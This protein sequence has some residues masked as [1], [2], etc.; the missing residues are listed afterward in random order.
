MR[1]K[2]IEKSQNEISNLLNCY[3]PK[4][5]IINELMI[6]S[7]LAP[8]YSSKQIA[9][10]TDKSNKTIEFHKESLKLKTGYSGSAPRTLRVFLLIAWRRCLITY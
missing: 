3:Y 10:I 8:G 9:G 6:L 1:H 5:I 7:F 4:G 2:D